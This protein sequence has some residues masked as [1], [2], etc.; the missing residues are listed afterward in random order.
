[1]SDERRWYYCL[2]HGRAE[3]G[4]GCPGR[5]RLGPYATED[6]ALNALEHARE[7]TERWDAENEEWREGPK[8]D[9]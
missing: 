3:A 9:S 6:E 5:H 4:P 8:H 2:K 7:R 1:M